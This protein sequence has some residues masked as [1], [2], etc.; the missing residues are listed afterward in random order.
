MKNFYEM[1]EEL[2]EF[3][4]YEL[5]FGGEG[6]LVGKK[7]DEFRSLIIAGEDVKSSNIRDLEESEGEKILV[8]FGE[9]T[10]EL[11]ELVDDAEIWDRELLIRRFGEMI[12]E[13][14]VIETATEGEVDFHIDHKRK[15]S[16]LKPL[17]DFEDVRELGEKMVKAY[18]YRLELVPHYIFRYR[19]DDKKGAMYMNAISGKKY[20]WDK[21]FERVSDIKRSHFKL[22]P[23]IAKEKAYDK[24]LE[25]VHERYSRE[26]KKEW[27]EEGATIVEKEK[28]VPDEIVLEGPTIVFVPMWAVE[29]TEGGIVII[30]AATGKVEHEPDHDGSIIYHG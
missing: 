14:S 16:T 17:I 13:K 3:D 11:E 18:R 7:G 22:E 15:E 10:Q 27:E 4:G 20:F 19:V 24:A 9:K 1:M 26:E 12:F 21:P 6:K 29:G 28:V 8:I 25:A 23:K 5:L 30:N 2:L